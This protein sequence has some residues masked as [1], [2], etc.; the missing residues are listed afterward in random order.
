MRHFILFI[1]ILFIFISCKT[2]TTPQSSVF[3]ILLPDTNRTHR[4]NI[5]FLHLKEVS[6]QINL[7]RIDTGMNG[8]EIRLWTSSM[9]IPNLIVVVRETDT[10]LL[11]QKIEYYMSPDSAAHYKLY[12]NQ[13]T[14]SLRI[15]LDS[16]QHY[17]FAKMISQNEIENFTDNLADGITYHLEISNSKYYKLLTYHCPEHFAKLEPNNKLFLE[18][19]L[20]LDRHLHF[21][22]PV[23]Y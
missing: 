2:K 13:Q 11:S 15:L 9:I 18:I 19:I 1:S 7:P 12:N 6:D 8:F 14:G 22:S 17:D 16:L 21:Y 5:I 10:V 23:C 4:P 3:Q 20:L